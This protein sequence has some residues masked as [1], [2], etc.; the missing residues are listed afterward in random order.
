MCLVMEWKVKVKHCVD[1]TVLCVCRVLDRLRIVCVCVCV[2]WSSFKEKV[3]CVCL[4]FGT[5]AA[6]MFV[7]SDGKWCV[8]V[9]VFM[10]MCMCNVVHL[11]I[12]YKWGEVRVT[13][14]RS[15]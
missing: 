4:S 10:Y 2:L 3:E 8:C 9:C 11:R 7:L 14:P 5:K 12:Q 13:L 1:N 15:P 6:A